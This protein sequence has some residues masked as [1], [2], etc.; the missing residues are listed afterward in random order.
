M[1]LKPNRAYT[2]V[3]LTDDTKQKIQDLIDAGHTTSITS[4]LLLAVDRLHQQ[5]IIDPIRPPTRKRERPIPWGVVFDK[6]DDGSGR[7]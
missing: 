4:T 1:T 6:E 2:T 3:M 5:E 7:K